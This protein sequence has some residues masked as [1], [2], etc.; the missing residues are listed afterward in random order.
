M[1]PFP[2]RSLARLAVA[3]G[4][5]YFLTGVGSLAIAL[6]DDGDLRIGWLWAAFTVSGFVLA[7]SL[8]LVVLVLSPA[9]VRRVTPGLGFLAMM[10]TPLIASCGVV[11]AGPAYSVV[12]AAY[13]QAPLFAFYTLRRKW[14]V[15]AWGL[16]I[17]CIT[18]ITIFQQGWDLGIW[19]WVVGSITG[20]SVVVGLIAARADELAA[21]E[22]DARLGLAE[23]NASLEE[24]VSSQVRE[25]ERLG[26][27][28]RFLSPQVADAML[29]ED[30]GAVTRPHRRRIAVFFCD[31]RGFT[32]FTNNAEPEEVIAV[33]DEYYRAV[34]GLMQRYDATVGDYAGDGVMAYF[35]DPVPRDDAALAAVEMTR[36]LVTE[37]APL[38][39][40]WQRRGFDLG[41]GVGIAFGYATLG[42]IGFDGRYD[43]KPVGGVVNLA[44]RLCSRAEPGQALLDHATH[45]ATVDR[46]P[47][48]HVG[49]VELKGYGAP[50]R[51]Y[52]LDA[53]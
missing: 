31:L 29:S 38:V 51:A 8:V 12:A 17:T 42:V 47:S 24:R 1:R 43:Y 52:A 40:E 46:H 21:A 16:V 36:E 3:G 7:A 34:G 28:R 10:V 49:D 48:T 18:L 11:A 19:V 15:A 20:T 6:A 45:A 23:L 27:L 32:A 26:A 14:A 9:A 4:L 50:I 5:L 37:L 39:G 22:H 35:G 13:V 2:T 25:I 30:S 44:A 41:F 53:R 33:L